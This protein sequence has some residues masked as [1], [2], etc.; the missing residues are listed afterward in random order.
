[1]SP[2]LPFRRPIRKN[3]PC[4][5]FHGGYELLEKRTQHESH[6]RLRLKVQARRGRRFRTLSVPSRVEAAQPPSFVEMGTCILG[7]LAIDG[8]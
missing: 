7:A 5:H 1:M 6:G 3:T 2:E 4:E 8:R